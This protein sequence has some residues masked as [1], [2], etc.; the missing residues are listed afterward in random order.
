MQ[1]R[2]SSLMSTLSLLLAGLLFPAGLPAQATLPASENPPSAASQNSVP[3]PQ[4][5]API[6][7]QPSS[8]SAAPVTPFGQI[9]GMVKSGTNPLP[10]VTVTA[11]NTLTGKKYI[12]STDVD[13]S[14]KIDVGAKGRYVVRAEFSAFAPATQEILINTEN[15]A[16][17]ADLSMVLLSRVQQQE[18]R[19][20]QQGQQLAGAGGR[21]LQQLS[22]G[23][24]DLGGAIA[25]GGG[26]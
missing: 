12:T 14:F 5:A 13:G 17:K 16:G 23:G 7:A 1:R 15:R 4:V 9:T 11:A 25:S 8:T 21:G 18:Q 24:G 2:S 19:Q 22:L 3:A 26:G 20:Q 6:N 10:G